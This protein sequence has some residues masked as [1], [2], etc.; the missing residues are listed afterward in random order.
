MHAT[1]VAQPNR[2]SPRANIYFGIKEPQNLSLS[3]RSTSLANIPY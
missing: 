3:S 1:K 2:N